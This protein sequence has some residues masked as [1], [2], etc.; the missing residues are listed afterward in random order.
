MKIV[1]PEELGMSVDASMSCDAL[2]TSVYVDDVVPTSCTY[3]IDDS[4]GNDD[5]YLKIA[6]LKPREFSYGIIIIGLVNPASAQRTT[7]IHCYT[8][9]DFDC[10][11]IV[12]ESTR[13]RFQWIPDV[14][15]ANNVEI[16]SDSLVNGAEDVTFRYDIVLGNKIVP[17]G[18]VTLVFPK[19][20]TY[21]IGDLGAPVRECLLYDCNEALLEVKV[22]TAFSKIAIA[23][24]EIE[25]DFF[26][27][28]FEE[29]DEMHDQI[30]IYLKNTV[31]VDEGL[32]MRI[33]LFPFKNPPISKALETFAGWTSDIDGN[34]IESWSDIHYHSDLPGVFSTNS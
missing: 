4:S 15:D 27:F 34:Q 7:D 19:Q 14:L 17:E 5:L 2:D 33:S 16:L 30:A 20:N 23:E 9:S 3:G 11:N 1:F 21:F 13:N 29:A 25:I 31:P 8:C 10:D 22:V 12:E 18:V 32:V 26:E 6:T 28:L 24:D